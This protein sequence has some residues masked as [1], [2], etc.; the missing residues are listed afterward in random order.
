MHCL[1]C[2]SDTD[3][4]NSRLQKRNNS[5]WRR[6]AC[7]QCGAVHTSIE[8]IDLAKSLLVRNAKN[9]N[10]PAQPFLRDKLF[11]SIY[12]SCKHRPT[13]LK[14]ASALTSTVLSALQPLIEQASVSNEDIAT[15]VGGALRRFDTAAYVQYAAYHR[16]T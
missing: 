13:A 8:T 16:L 7:R 9:P 5:V 10:L 15:K 11:V 12:T 1:Y 2:G 3:V 4:T 6:R 14:D